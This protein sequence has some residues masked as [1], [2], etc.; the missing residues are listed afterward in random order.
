M[1]NHALFIGFGMLIWGAMGMLAYHFLGLLAPY[2]DY[3]KQLEFEE[4]RNKCFVLGIVGVFLA[5]SHA[6][7]RNGR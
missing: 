6:I 2:K 5:L 1:E 4:F 7:D 3:N